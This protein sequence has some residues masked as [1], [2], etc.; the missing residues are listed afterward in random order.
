MKQRLI[1]NARRYT[2]SPFAQHVCAPGTINQGAARRPSSSRVGADVI[3]DQADET[4]RSS[5]GSAGFMFGAAT[6]QGPKAI[7]LSLSLKRYVKF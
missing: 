5:Q 4:G 7:F 6:E 1:R 2:R 3:S